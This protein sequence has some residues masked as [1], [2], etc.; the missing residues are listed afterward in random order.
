MWIFSRAAYA[1]EKTLTIEPVA[2][3][4]RVL[5]FLV[6]VVGLIVLLAWLVNKSKMTSDLMQNNSDLKVIASHSLGV[7]EKILVLKVGESQF[8]VGVTAQNI[9]LLSELDKPLEIKPVNA[10]SF[11]D[12]L[13]KAVKS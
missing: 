10:L 1:A 2:N 12:L 11:S 13:K 5:F 6:L 8:L 9:N 3:A 4:G 7:K